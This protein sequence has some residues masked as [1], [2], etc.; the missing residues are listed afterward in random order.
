[1]RWIDCSIFFSSLRSRSRVRRLQGVLFLDGGRSAGSDPRSPCLRAGA[2]WSRRRW[3]GFPVSSWDSLSRKNA[4]CLSFMY[5]ESGMAMTSASD[6]WSTGLVFQLLASLGVFRTARGGGGTSTGEKWFGV[7]TL[8]RWT[9]PMRHGRHSDLGEPRRRFRRPGR[10]GWGHGGAGATGG[11]AGFATAFAAADLR[12]GRRLAAFGGR[13]A[14]LVATG[15]IDLVWQWPPLM[16][17]TGFATG[18]VLVTGLA[19]GLRFGC[20]LGLSRRFIFAAGFATGLAT[21]LALG[22][23][24]RGWLLGRQL[25]TALALAGLQTPLGLA[26]F[27]W[28]FTFCLLAAGGLRPPPRP[29]TL[30][31]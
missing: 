18:L 4:I 26:F 31:F 17:A 6:S 2:R 13:R 1:M 23:R 20:R 24:L 7:M 15:S 19:T 9:P 8:P 14:A 3:P 16:L 30:L 12:A 27:G 10:G 25:F 29:G 11:T 5:S 21:G 22:G 28:G